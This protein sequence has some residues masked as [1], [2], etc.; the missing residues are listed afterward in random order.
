MHLRSASQYQVINYL[1]HSVQG[2][3]VGLSWVRE[4]L[5]EGGICMHVCTVRVCVWV[6]CV[7][8]CIYLC[9]V[10]TY[11]TYV[12]ICMYRFMYCMCLH[13]YM[14]IMYECVWLCAHVLMFVYLHSMSSCVRA[15]MISY[16]RW[17]WPRESSYLGYSSFHTVIRASFL[18]F[19]LH[20]CSWDTNTLMWRMCYRISWCNIVKCR[21]V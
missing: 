1:V 15:C 7:C 19:V 12:C 2:C 11:I 18:S 9:K 6:R 4:N 5:L 14:C 20:R 21:L 17:F 13:E 3:H 8:M 16:H 10:F